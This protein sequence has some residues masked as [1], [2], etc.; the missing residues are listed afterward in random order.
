MRAGSKTVDGMTG[1]VTAVPAENTKL[2]QQQRS[3]Q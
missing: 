2:S 3:K 1:A